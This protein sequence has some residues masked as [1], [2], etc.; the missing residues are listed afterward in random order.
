MSGLVFTMPVAM[1]AANYNVRISIGMLVMA[2]AG[3]VCAIVA[4]LMLPET[5]GRDLREVGP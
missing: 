4:T 2:L 1:I 5:A 3:I